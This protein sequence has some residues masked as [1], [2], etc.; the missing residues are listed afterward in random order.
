[1]SRMEGTDRTAP[2]RSL[3]RATFLRGCGAV[4]LSVPFAAKLALPAAA[5]AQKAADMEALNTLLR[6]EYVLVAFFETAIDHLDLA[7]PKRRLAEATSDDDQS[8][9]RGLKNLIRDHGAKPADQPAVLFESL[10]DLESFLDTA[11]ELKDLS[12]SAYAG[13]LGVV[14]PRVVFGSLASILQIDGRHAA[15]MRLAAGLRPAPT[16]FANQLTMEQVRR[17]LKRFVEP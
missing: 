5:A 1:M 2:A 15:H 12:V 11:V 8:H 17:K 14:E 10:D 7:P 6:L 16:A 13:A 4:G 3:T 9:V